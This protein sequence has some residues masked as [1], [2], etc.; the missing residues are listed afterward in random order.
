MGKFSTGL[1]TGAVLG[2]G[3]LAMDKKNIKK[4][5][6]FINRLPYNKMWL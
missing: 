5:R 4:A 3:L 1:L 2:I 6:K